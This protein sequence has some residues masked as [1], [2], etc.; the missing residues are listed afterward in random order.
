MSKEGT[1]CGEITAVG[2]II[3][4]ELLAAFTDWEP[5]VQALLRV[6]IIYTNTDNGMVLK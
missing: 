4:D 5:E 3:K 1:T 6:R 2:S